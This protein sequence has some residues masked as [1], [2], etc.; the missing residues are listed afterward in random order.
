MLNI[1]LFGDNGETGGVGWRMDVRGKESWLGLGFFVKG[2]PRSTD[3]WAVCRLA[4]R[5][6]GLELLL[7][8]E[9][10]GVVLDMD[11]LRRLEERI[12]PD[13]DGGRSSVWS[14]PREERVRLR[15]RGFGFG[16]LSWTGWILMQG[17]GAAS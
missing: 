5:W 16:P 10:V 7:V 13:P 1:A 11:Q 2:G 12:A 17:E 15:A 14:L 4:G 9:V 3:V 8:S 6:K